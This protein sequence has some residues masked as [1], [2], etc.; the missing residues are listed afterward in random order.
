M[1]DVKTHWCNGFALLFPYMCHFSILS[2]V[3]FYNNLPRFFPFFSFTLINSHQTFT[4]TA[5]DFNL[6][7]FISFHMS[8]W[9]DC[10]SSKVKCNKFHWQWVIFIGS[11]KS[12]KDMNISKWWNVI[13]E[14]KH[15]WN[16]IHIRSN[17]L[18]FFQFDLKTKFEYL[19]L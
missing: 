18:I 7:K 10:C 8:Y 2:F 9:F 15:N 4:L 6:F 19:S 3:L 5:N 17:Q 16:R 12:F 14:K 11:C 13:R 1:C